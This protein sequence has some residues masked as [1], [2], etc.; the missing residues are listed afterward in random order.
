MI[1]PVEVVLQKSVCVAGLLRD[2]FKC[3]RQK[4]QPHGW[5]VHNCLKNLPE[6]MSLFTAVLLEAVVMII[7]LMGQVRDLSFRVLG[8]DCIT[9]KSKFPSSFESCQLSRILLLKF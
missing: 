3:E 9:S 5:F 8:V 7:S 2:S 6:V 4:S 1:L